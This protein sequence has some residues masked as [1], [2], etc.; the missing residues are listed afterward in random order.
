MPIDITTERV[1]TFRE[2][3]KEYCPR[4]R[5]G[6]KPH[7]STF[8]RWARMGLET[9][10]VGGQLCTSVEAL[11]RFFDSLSGPASPTRRPAATPRRVVCTPDQ[12]ERELT[13]LGL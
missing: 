11:Q 2:A 3:A 7:I 12:V 10:Q 1:V 8:Y 4:R 13:T 5:H 6:R 9:I